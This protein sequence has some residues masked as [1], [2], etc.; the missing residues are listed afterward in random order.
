MVLI[1]M[2][3]IKMVNIKIQVFFK[4]KKNIN[5]LKDEDEF[6]KLYNEIIKNGEFR[7]KINKKNSISSYDFKKFLESILNGKVDDNEILKKLKGINEMENYLND[8]KENE[9]INK[10]NNYIKKIKN[11]IFGKVKSKIRTEKARS[12]K[13][14]KGK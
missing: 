6:L 10:L 2:V 12:F 4:I 14:Q 3:L 8:L 9:N 1:D 11:S 5:W 13:D 7:E